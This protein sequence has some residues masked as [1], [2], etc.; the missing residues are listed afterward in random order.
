MIREVWAERT[1]G[2]QKIEEEEQQQRVCDRILV[3]AA[4]SSACDMM[5]YGQAADRLG[6]SI[7][8]SYCRR[9]AVSVI[10]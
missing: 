9:M 10:E 5:L 4:S 1:T 3:A 6:L 2:Y 7:C 8:G